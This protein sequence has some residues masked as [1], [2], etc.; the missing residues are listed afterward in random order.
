MDNFPENDAESVQHAVS[1]DS[2]TIPN[3]NLVGKLDGVFHHRYHSPICGMY[4][5]QSENDNNEKYKITTKYFSHL[6]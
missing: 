5:T 1:D 3:V 4:T 6:F 2:N